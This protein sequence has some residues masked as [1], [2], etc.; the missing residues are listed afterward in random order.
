M[1]VLLL[2][3]VAALFFLSLKPAEKPNPTPQACD[4]FEGKPVNY[5]CEGNELVY[6]SCRNGSLGALRQD[7]GNLVCDDFAVV[8][9]EQRADCIES[10]AVSS[11]TPSVSPSA[12]ASLVP[13]AGSGLAP[14][15]CGDG[16]CDAPENCAS[17]A[18]DCACG[19]RDQC[20]LTTGTC[21]ARDACGD[22]VCSTLEGEGF[23]CCVDC[24]CT[25]GRLCD[26]YDNAC[27]ETEGL[28]SD[29][30]ASQAALGYFAANATHQYN[31]SLVL[32]YAFA[33]DLFKLV[34]LDCVNVTEYAC[35]AWV[36]VNST[37]SVVSVSH[38]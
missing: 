12:Q 2:A 18:S 11:A 8:G 5:R 25:G 14:H 19:S 38:T 34:I 3:G 7:C 9:G 29:D 21:R 16:S 13:Y 31:V 37:G 32:P 22:G 23:S 24:G 27:V 15:Y 17:C 33:G 20:N 28:A 30:A 10:S 35:Q 26:R 4:G 36:T 6:D 1:A